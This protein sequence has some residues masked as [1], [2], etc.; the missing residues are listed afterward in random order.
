MKPLEDSGDVAPHLSSNMQVFCKGV[1]NPREPYTHYTTEVER[2][3]IK[4]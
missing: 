1:R 3:K 2:L 4:T